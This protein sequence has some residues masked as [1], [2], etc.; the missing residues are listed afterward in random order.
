M[1]RIQRDANGDVVFRVSA[2][3]AADN[4]SAGAAVR[5][6]QHSNARVSGVQS[7]VIGLLVVFS[8][9][10]VYAQSASTGALIGTVTDPTGAILQNA[11]IALRNTGTGERRTVITDRDGSYRFSLLTPGEYE[12]T[13]EAVGFAPHVVRDVLIRITEVSRL[14]TQLAVEGLR[15]DLVVE[16]PLL[17]TDSAALGRV[18]ARD[19]I[20][21]LPLVNRKFTQILGLL[22][23]KNH[24]VVDAWH[25]GSGG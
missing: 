5:K 15:Q 3:L 8:P 25:L 14:A 11:R 7:L 22:A 12:V 2:P 19:T 4:L 20:V 6:R 17:Q 23:G 21:G 10:D 16:A 24:D 9:L 13:L 1:L 18:I